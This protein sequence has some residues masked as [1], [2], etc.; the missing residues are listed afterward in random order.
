MLW[1]G[2]HASQLFVGWVSELAV[3]DKSWE[4][5][6]SQ[7]SGTDTLVGSSCGSLSVIL[8]ALSCYS[9]PPQLHHCRDVSHFLGSNASLETVSLSACQMMKVVPTAT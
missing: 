4:D 1:P 9:P 7:P 8:G 6:L 2:S 5:H 3:G